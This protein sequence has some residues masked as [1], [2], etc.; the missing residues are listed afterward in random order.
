MRKVVAGTGFHSLSISREKLWIASG[1]VVAVMLLAGCSGSDGNKEP[2]VDSVEEST[3]TESRSGDGADAEVDDLESGRPQLRMDTSAIEELRMT[4]GYLQCL[5]DQGVKVSKG[6]TK[7]EGGDPDLLWWP[8]GDMA[9]DH[10]DAEKKCLGKKPL[11]PP[12]TDPKKNPNYMGDYADW[13]A[14]MNKKG[15]KVDPLPNGGGWNYKAG[16]TPPRNAD[17]I[18]QECMIEAFS[19]E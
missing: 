3:G 10:P 8:N 6:G 14:C 5:K 16:T 19:E 17:Q 12:E 1:A 11:Q 2:G 4:Q 13:I 9:A 18:D 7:L 15:F